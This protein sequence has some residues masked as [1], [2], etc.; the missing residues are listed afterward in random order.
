M[1]C[2]VGPVSSSMLRA[3]ATSHSSVS[4]GHYVP[5]QPCGYSSANGVEVD[6]FRRDGEAVHLAGV[7]ADQVSPQ[8]LTQSPDVGVQHTSH[9]LRCA[10]RPQVLGERVDADRL[11]GRERQRGQQDP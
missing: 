8:Q 5:V 2:A 10:V 11:V 3:V 9:A 4:R 6:G 1:T 7:G